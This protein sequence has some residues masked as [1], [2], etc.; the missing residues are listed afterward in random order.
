MIVPGTSFLTFEIE[1]ESDAGGNQDLNRTIVNNLGRAIIK[2]L[3]VKLE[4][5][6]IF[7][8]DASDIYHCYKDLWKTTKERENAVYQGIQSKA[9]RKIRIDAGDKGAVAKDVAVG[10]AYS[11]KL[12]IPLDFELLS[13]SAPF[14]PSE[15][16]D[17]LTYELTF[18]DND[19]V[20]VSTDTNAKYTV[21]NIEL[22]FE[23]IN[24][25]DLATTMRNIHKGKS[26]VY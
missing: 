1:L 26:I 20:V 25:D 9:V 12:C 7:T 11:N 2:K 19:K 13:A 22:K 15:I 17:K 23:T 24:S 21:S 18:N 10:T 14:F 5:R 6:S 3:E 8:L 4:G 16:R